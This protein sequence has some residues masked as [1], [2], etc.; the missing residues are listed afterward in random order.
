M[1]VTK[2]VA[3]LVVLQ[4]HWCLDPTTLSVSK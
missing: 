2:N 1:T 4:T 3:L